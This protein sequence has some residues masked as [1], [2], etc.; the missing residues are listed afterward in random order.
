M[1]AAPIVVESPMPPRRGLERKAGRLMKNEL[2]DTLQ[3]KE[4]NFI[5]LIHFNIKIELLY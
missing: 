5:V 2:E 1:K 3:K 4:K